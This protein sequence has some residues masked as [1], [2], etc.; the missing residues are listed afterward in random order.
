V[1]VVLHGAMMAAAAMGL[2]TCPLGTGDSI[3]FG[4]I[5]GLD[6][7]SEV[8]VGEFVLGTPEE[9]PNQARTFI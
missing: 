9:A 6:P 2:G 5:T 3:L 7:R 8:S 4:E 1:G